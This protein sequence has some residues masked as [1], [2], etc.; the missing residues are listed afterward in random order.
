MKTCFVVMAIGDQTYE[1]KS[2]TASE[3]RGRYTGLIKESIESISIDIKVIRADDVSDSGSISADIF[4]R[5]ISSD[6][7]VV[8]ITYP[9]PNVFY[10]LGLCHAIRNKTILIK[11]KNSKNTPFDISGLRYIEYQDSG[12][13]LKELKGR[14]AD[15]FAIYDEKPNHLD[16][17]FMIMAISMGMRFQQIV[18]D[19][20]KNAKKIAMQ[21]LFKN[22][23]LLAAVSNPDDRHLV[24]LFVNDENLETIIDGLV[25]SGEFDD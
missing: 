16:N 1:G 20:K 25:D 23:E 2:I 18:N 7:V 17:D 15:A 6:Y 12:I 19:P 22:K 4:K 9:N 24:E 8:D 11:E 13:G 3:L 5:L 21:A 14:L 10:E